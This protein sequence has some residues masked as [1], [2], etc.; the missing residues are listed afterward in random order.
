MT[1]FLLYLFPAL[2][3]LLLGSFF[4]VSTVRIA[5]SGGSALAVSTVITLWGVC[6]MIGSYAIGHMV[7]ESNCRPLTVIGTA[8]I[9]LCAAAFIVIPSLGALYLIMAV[10]GFAVA[11][12]FPPY[13]F[14]MKL[15]EQCGNRHMLPSV[16]LYTMAWSLGLA[17]GPFVGGPVWSRW[18]WQWVIGLDAALG[19]V[20]LGLLFVLF[21]YVDKARAARTASAAAGPVEA[22]DTLKRPDLAWLAW[23]GSGTC[24]LAM[25]MVRGVFP[26]VAHSLSIPKADQG[27]A[28]GL[29]CIGQALVAVALVRGR[30]WVYRAGPVAGFGAAGLAGLMLFGLARGSL[31]FYAAAL[32]IGVYA[33]ASFIYVAYHALVHP[34][35]AGK[36][37]GINEAIVGLTG[38]VGP[39]LAGFIADSVGMSVPFYVA[40][41]L[42]ALA[43]VFQT[44]VHMRVRV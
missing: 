16:A 38:I 22:V 17:A 19:L 5:E 8:G 12:F 20:T 40:A 21:H 35:R 33:G 10:F 13:M 3:D 27:I 37:I 39:A 9:T 18:G 6:Y 44:S 25:A 30:T 41:L 2:I 42:V 31:V 4:F 15:V 7:T 43:V 24:M 11:L 28:L 34:S 23:M 36:Y 32:C 29:V 14:H 26:T 1:R